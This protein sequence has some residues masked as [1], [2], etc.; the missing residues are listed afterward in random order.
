MLH[1]RPPEPPPDLLCTEARRRIWAHLRR[2]GRVLITQDSRAVT[3]QGVELGNQIAAQ[4]LLFAG[5]CEWHSAEQWTLV[6]P[7]DAARPQLMEVARA[8]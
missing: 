6:R 7:G 8:P 4:E 3:A 1:E 5:W 2:G